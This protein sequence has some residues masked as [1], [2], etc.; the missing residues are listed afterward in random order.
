LEMQVNDL[1]NLGQSV[2]TIFCLNQEKG[3]GCGGSIPTISYTYIRVCR[4][5]VVVSCG[6]GIKDLLHFSRVNS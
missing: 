6:G 4:F 5:D 1:T 3:V 2:M